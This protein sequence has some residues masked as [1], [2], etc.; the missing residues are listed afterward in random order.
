MR[1]DALVFAISGTFFGLIVG[2]ILGSQNARPVAGLP[3]AASPAAAA[4]TTASPPP[5][6][7]RRATDLEAQAKARPGDARVRLELANLYYDAERFDLAVP[8]Y[9]DTLA[10]TPTDVGASTD[11]AVCYFYTNQV[12][13]ALAQL[14]RSLA[15]DPNHAKTL[16]NQGII[17]AQGKGDLAAATESWKRVLLVAPDGEEGR[18]ARQLLDGLQGHPTLPAA[19][20]GSGGGLPPGAP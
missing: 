7:V 16:L 9:L 15:I 17:L 19:G 6:D 18:L 8:W 5:L 3:V 1:R 20:A 12:D 14:E 2:W 4:S 11:L 13:Q 10:I